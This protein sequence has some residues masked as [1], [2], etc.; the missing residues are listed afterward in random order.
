[1]SNRARLENHLNAALAYSRDRED[2]DL[3]I[4][5][6]LAVEEMFGVFIPASVL[7]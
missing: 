3:T 7:V 1:M 2:D 5:Q 6:I 4:K